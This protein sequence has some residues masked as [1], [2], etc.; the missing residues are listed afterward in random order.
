M[1]IFEKL[2]TEIEKHAVENFRPWLYVMTKH[3]C[4][5]QLQK[6]TS[7][8]KKIKQF[9][10][11]K[12]M[13]S[14]IEL[15]PLDETPEKDMNKALAECIEKLKKEQKACIVLF[16]FKENCYREISLKLELPVNKVKSYI[17]NG[18]RNLKICLENK[19]G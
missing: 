11:E 1:Q 18:K 8:S 5:R 2:I 16:Y 9:Y 13:E 3:H 15:S 6:K 4:L 14:T 17:Q 7:A 12:I 19:N 10:D